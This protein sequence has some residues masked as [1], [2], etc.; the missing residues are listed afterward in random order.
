MGAKSYI[1]AGKVFDVLKGYIDVLMQFKG[2]SRAGVIIKEAD[3]TSKVLQVA[4]KPFGTSLMQWVEI[5]KAWQYAYKNNI[6]FQLRL[7]K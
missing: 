1:G 3:I 7:I 4:I 5:A 2:G 6:G